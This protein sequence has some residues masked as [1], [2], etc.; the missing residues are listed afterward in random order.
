MRFIGLNHVFYERVKLLA[1][2]A[3]S[4]AQ[5]NLVGDHRRMALNRNLDDLCGM[6]QYVPEKDYKNR[7]S[8][9]YENCNG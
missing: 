3:K 1:Y 5:G 2:M 9:T 6:L 7:E 4:F 8:K